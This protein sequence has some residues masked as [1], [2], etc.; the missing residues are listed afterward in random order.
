MNWLDEVSWLDRVNMYAVRAWVDIVVWGLAASVGA[1][2][3]GVLGLEVQYRWRQS[4]GG[5]E[6]R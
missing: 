3:L 6:R 4:R 1:V 2:V 5:R